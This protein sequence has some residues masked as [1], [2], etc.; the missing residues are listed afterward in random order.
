MDHRVL[1]DLLARDRRSDRP[2]L[3]APAERRSYTWRDLCTTSYKAGNVL[4]YLGVRHG[5][6]V[7]VAPEPGPDPVLALLGA[8]HLGAVV[9]FHQP[10]GESLE[11]DPPRVVLV[12]AARESEVET[13]PGTN[14]A[15][16]GGS[17]AD[18]STTHWEAELWSENPA[19][20][21]TD[22]APDDPVLAVDGRQFAHGRLLEAAEEAADRV[23]LSAE[24][25]VAV[26]GPVGDSRV[27]AAGVFAP[28]AVGGS[29]VL[30][31]GDDSYDVGVGV[32]T[33]GSTRDGRWLDVTQLP[34][35]RPRRRR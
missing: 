6:V 5:S 24:D 8:A 19:V 4:R 25:A 14:L 9:R 27:L 2:A 35:D 28:L 3:L 26:R 7:A 21:P 15:V 32:G 13:A 18:P 34:T 30:A 11:R 1:G 20:H 33:D 29:F 17:P 16:Y 10:T 31:G 12:P 22:V 23:D